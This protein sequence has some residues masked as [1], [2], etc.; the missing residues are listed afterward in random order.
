MLPTRD[1]S[2]AD[3][4]GLAARRERE[5]EAEAFLFDRADV[6]AAAAPAAAARCRAGRRV[7]A[8]GSR[9]RVDRRAAAERPARLRRATVVAERAEQRVD[10]EDG[11]AGRVAARRVL[12]DVGADE[13]RAAVTVAAGAGVVARDDRARD[14][15]R[16]ADAVEAATV[17]VVRVVVR[18]RRRGEVR[19]AGTRDAAAAVG[20]VAVEGAVLNRRGGRR[21]RR[22]HPC[23]SR[24]CPGTS[25]CEMVAVPSTSTPAPLTALLPLTVDR[26]SVRFA[27]LLTRM[28]PPSPFDWSTVAYDDAIDRHAGG[29]RR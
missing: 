16:A 19:R 20:R 17:R 18:H 13:G 10:D 8:H 28:P 3:A 26:F 2:G 27:F 21:C 24:C 1:G 4:D 7:V 11:A 9:V 12:Q 5:V 29:G 22:R 23:R 25:I 6:A 15:E 14:V